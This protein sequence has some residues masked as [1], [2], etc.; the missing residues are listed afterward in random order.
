MPGGILLTIAILSEV[1]ATLALRLSHGF[2]RPLPSVI[3]VLGYAVS[4][5]MLALVLK[6]LPIG[7]TYAVWAGAGTALVAVA[8]IVGFGESATALKFASLA[9]IVLGVVGLNLTGSH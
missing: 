8:G 1:T 7:F 6:Q 4:F 3:V 5:W 9:L 2:S